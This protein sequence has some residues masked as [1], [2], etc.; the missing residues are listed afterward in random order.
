MLQFTRLVPKDHWNIRYRRLM[1]ETG[2]ALMENKKTTHKQDAPGEENVDNGRIGYPTDRE[3]DATSSLPQRHG[4]NTRENLSQKSGN[5]QPTSAERQK[6]S[7][8]P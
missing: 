6:T 3:S 1:L 7:R 5:K 8:K 4:W 2:V